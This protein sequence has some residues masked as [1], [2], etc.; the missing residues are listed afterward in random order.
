MDIRAG[1]LLGVLFGGAV[2]A[3]ALT[4]R[5]SA[6]LATANEATR[7]SYSTITSKKQVGAK[8]HLQAVLAS[9]LDGQL[10]Q[11]H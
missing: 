4:R 10:A 1:S 6:L 11:V 5:A 9:D 7:Q 2:G 8:T 3:G